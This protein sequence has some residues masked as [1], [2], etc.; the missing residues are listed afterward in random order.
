MDTGLGVATHLIGT[1]ASIGQLAA[2]PM[3][4]VT[5]LLIAR[6][7]SGPTFVGASLAMAFSLLP[8]ALIPRMGAVSLGFIGVVATAAVWRPPIMMYR[9]AIVP[10][11]WRAVMSGATNMAMGFAWA[12]MGLGGAQIAQNV[13]YGAVFL[14]GAISTTCG[15]LLFWLFDRVPH[16][17]FATRA[18]PKT[19]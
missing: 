2:V 12:A 18:V 7:R 14:I 5:P 17:E 11:R 13:G 8:M 3:A 9:M 4:F 19:P 16:G 10:P 15:A 6:W 1:M